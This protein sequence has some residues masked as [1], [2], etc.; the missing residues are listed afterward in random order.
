MPRPRRGAQSGPPAA[1]SYLTPSLFRHPSRYPACYPLSPYIQTLLQSCISVLI[2]SIA[3]PC[4]DQ[5][6]V[7]HQKSQKIAPKKP[8]G[9]H[10]C[11]ALVGISIFH[12]SAL[13]PHDCT[14]L[15]FVQC[16]TEPNQCVEL[17]EQQ[18]SE[19][20]GDGVSSRLRSC[21]Y[22]IYMESQNQSFE[23]TWV[24]TNLPVVDINPNS[25]YKRG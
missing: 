5:M 16:H 10:C 14:R 8:N 9:L 25:T 13:S 15:V 6:Q 12:V 20:S 22:Q 23:Y 4:A 11:K 2:S 21:S 19:E 7:Y 3:V 1:S 24:R 17:G 18:A